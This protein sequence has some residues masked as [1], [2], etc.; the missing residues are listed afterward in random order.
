M[1]IIKNVLLFNRPII[2]R[3]MDRPNVRYPYRPYLSV[4]PP[5]AQPRRQNNAATQ[6]ERDG[7]TK[8][9]SES[10]R[11]HELHTYVVQSSLKRISF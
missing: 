7:T 3:S 10:G 11:E 4:P 5:A 8:S 2:W 1:R 9:D 6:R